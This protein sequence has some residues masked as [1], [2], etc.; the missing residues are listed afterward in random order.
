MWP[1]EVVERDHEIQNPTSPEKIRRLGHYLRLSAESRVVDIACGKGGPALVLA[2]AYGCRVLGIEVRAAFAEEARRRAAA[3]GLASLIDVRTADAARVELEPEAC[4]AAI[5][6]GA[7][8]VWGTIAE[9]AAALRPAIREGG[10]V[11]IGEPFWRHWPL[12][13]DVDA[14]TYVALDATVEGDGKVTLPI[15]RDAPLSLAIWDCLEAI[16]PSKAAT[17]LFRCS[18]WAC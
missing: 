10:F 18:N 1:W 8:F 14:C 17:W 11:A 16:S 6:L 3:A 13:P 9:A 4:D 12:P 15:T 7:S 5:C 2:R